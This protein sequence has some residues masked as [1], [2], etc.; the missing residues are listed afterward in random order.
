MDRRKR[1]AIF[2]LD[3]TLLNTLEDLTDSMNYILEVNGF[4]LRTLEEIRSFVGNGV[5]KLVE[6]AIPEDKRSDS[7]FVDKLYKD[8][9]LYYNEHC[10]IKTDLY[11]GIKE[12]VE[13]LTQNGY[14]C[15]IVSNKIDSAVKE[16]SD[17]Y[18]GSLMKA[19]IGEI[20][21]VK[22][23]PAPDMVELAMKEMGAVKERTIYI[24][25]SE[26]DVQTAKNSGLP[27][28]SVLWGFRD[29]EFLAEKGA[30]VFV[31]S[32]EELLEYL[33]KF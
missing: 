4:P 22:T 10:M 7:V 28:V 24:G 18:F 1:Y 26:V 20:P 14:D 2:D 31:H 15:A 16:L 27:S 11:D 9:S 32:A 29:K 21:S 23:K 19:S 25:D 17:K 30:E 6:R 13:N 3:G 12:L 8:F 5:R 33:L